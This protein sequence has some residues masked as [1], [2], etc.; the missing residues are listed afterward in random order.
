VSRVRKLL[1]VLVLVLAAM[2]MLAG[3]AGAIVHGFTPVE[4]A[5]SDNAGGVQ[6]ADDNP[7]FKGQPIPV[8]SSDGK[9]QGKADSAPA[10]C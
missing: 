8:T 10:N 3:P 7:Q 5:N 6:A 9:T 2:V 1:I 4:C